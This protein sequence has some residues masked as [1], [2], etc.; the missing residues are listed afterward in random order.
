[1]SHT[2]ETIEHESNPSLRVRIGLDESPD[3]PYDDGGSPILH[4]ACGTWT[5]G[6]WAAEQ[7]TDITSYV[8][9]PTIEDAAAKWGSEPDIFERYLR[10]FHGVTEVKWYTPREGGNYVTF[11]PADW[12]EK[13]GLPVDKIELA[14]YAEK[15]DLKPGWLASLEEW[16]SYCEGDVYGYVVEKRV[17]WKP[18]DVD[19]DNDVTMET[20]EH[21]EDGSLWG[22]Y[23]FTYAEEAAREALDSEAG[24]AGTV[25][26]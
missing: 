24:Y 9:D 8:V 5:D 26:A 7:M 23:G 10:I 12:R 15:H 14:A 21:V 19:A 13:M 16:I 11:D 25:T 3:E 2:V 1:M 20:W 22:L 17:T 18:V 4:V 6:R